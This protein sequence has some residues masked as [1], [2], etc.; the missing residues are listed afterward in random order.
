MLAL[1]GELRCRRC[2]IC[3]RDDTIR[4]PVQ[5]DRRHSDDRLRGEPLLNI[6][7]RW[8]ALCKAKAMAVGMDHDVHI[9]SR[10]CRTRLRADGA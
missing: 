4:A 9:H 10:G 6:L 3:C 8:V 5:R 1:A 7:V 2:P